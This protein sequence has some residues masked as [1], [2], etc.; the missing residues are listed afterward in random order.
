MP[1]LSCEK[2]SIVKTASRSL[3][4]F[5]VSHASVCSV[6]RSA[7]VCQ[8]WDSRWKIGLG[9]GDG[10]G[11]QSPNRL[12]CFVGISG[13]EHCLNCHHPSRN[14]RAARE[15]LCSVDW[16]TANADRWSVI[17]SQAVGY[18]QGSSIGTKSSRCKGRNYVCGIILNESIAGCTIGVQKD[19]AFSLW[20]KTRLCSFLAYSM[21]MEIRIVNWSASFCPLQNCSPAQDP[22][23]S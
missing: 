23:S 20:L 9:H 18:N 19:C 2:F 6:G 17:S 12:L 1:L 3:L 21:A 15:V 5:A 8:R 16:S 4:P 14:E 10:G 11:S 13:T 22:L 7:L